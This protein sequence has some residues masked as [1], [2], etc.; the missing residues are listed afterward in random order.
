MEVMESKVKIFNAQWPVGSLVTV[1]KDFGEC[2]ETKIRFPAQVLS[3]H[4]AVIWLENISGAYVLNRV[5]AH[6][7]RVK[8][9]E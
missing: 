3:G 1:I 2:V 8:H 6:S 4:T 5:V 9:E 7:R